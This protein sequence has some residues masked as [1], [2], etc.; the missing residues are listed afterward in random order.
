MKQVIRAVQALV[1]LPPSVPTPANLRYRQAVARLDEI[2]YRIIRERRASRRDEGDFLSMLLLAQDEDDGAVMTDEQVRDE[3]MTLLVAGH[4]TTA[5]ALSW[6][7]YLLA[8]HPEARRRLEQEVSAV[9]DGRP[10]AFEDLARLPYT[11]AVLKEAMRHFPPVYLLGRRAL[12]DVPVGGDRIEKGELVMV[13]IHAMHRRPEY[14]PDPE[15]FRP[16]RFLDGAEA[17]IPRYAYLPFGAGPRVC[18]GNHFALME[19][20][21][22]LASLAQRVQL[23]LPPGARVTPEALITLRPRGGLPMRVRR[24]APAAGAGT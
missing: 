5:N 23:D 4:E 2:V 12:R 15:A 3:V 20:H 21:L 10:P 24:R 13:N 1:P 7:L 11:L 9:L 6:T 8:R 16:E 19:G 17:S 22:A 18:I 14:F